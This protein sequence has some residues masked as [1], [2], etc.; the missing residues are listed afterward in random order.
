MVIF[1]LNCEYPIEI[2]M[3]AGIFGL[4]ESVG[5][6]MSLNH[7]EKQRGACNILTA[8]RIYS[9]FTTR[10]ISKTA[11]KSRGRL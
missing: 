10:P 3:F 8:V 11:A 1:H 6:V 2:H 4:V 7:N 5:L 9:P